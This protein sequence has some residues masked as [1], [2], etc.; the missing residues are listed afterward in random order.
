MQRWKHGIAVLCTA[1]LVAGCGGTSQAQQQTATPPPSTGGGSTGAPQR[2][3]SRQVVLQDADLPIGFTQLASKPIPLAR[4][5]QHESRSAMAADRRSYLGG[6][7]T[8]YSN[9]V[10]VVESTASVYKNAHD[11][12][13]VL[14]DPV[15]LHRG[16]TELH[17]HLIHVPRGAPGQDGLLIAGHVTS[18]GH[19][20]PLLAYGWRDGRALCLLAVAGQSGVASQLGELSRIEDGHASQLGLTG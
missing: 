3:V 4:E 17:G 20:I 2:D 14:T 5:L 7:E 9:G 18:S 8:T 6:F 12:H 16:L 15:G 10:V 13:L 19:R 11:A 1:A